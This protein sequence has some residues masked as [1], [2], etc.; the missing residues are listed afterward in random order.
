[1][2]ELGECHSEVTTEVKKLRRMIN[3]QNRYRLFFFLTRSFFFSGDSSLG[4]SS[5]CRLPQFKTTFLFFFFVILVFFPLAGFSASYSSVQSGDWNDPATWGGSGVP[6]SGDDVRINSGDEVTY[7]GDLNWTSGTISGNIDLIVTGDFSVSG[8]AFSVWSTLSVQ[9]GGDFIYSIGSFPMDSGYFLQVDGSFTSTTGGLNNSS[10]NTIMIGE[11]V[12]VDGDIILNNGA[13]TIGGNMTSTNGKVEVNN[14]SSLTI[15]G[16]LQVASSIKLNNGTLYVDGNSSATSLEVNN[17]STFFSGQDLAIGNSIVVNGGVIDVNG[18][19]STSDITLNNTSILAIDGDLIKDGNITINSVNSDLVVAGDFV[20]SGGGTTINND[21]GFYVFQFLDETS[22]QANCQAGCF[23]QEICN[24]C[25]IKSYAEWTVDSSPAEDYLD[26]HGGI[27]YSSGT[28]TVPDGV[29]SITVEVWGAGG[30]GATITSKNT[31]GGGGGGG[32]Y[33]SSIL[34]VTP[35]DTYNFIVGSGGTNGTNGGTTSFNSNSVV[36]EGGKGAE[37]NSNIGA[38]GGSSLNSVGNTIFDGGNGGNGGNGNN[39]NSGAGGGGAGS[40]GNGGDASGMTTGLGAN[41]N[42]GDGGVGVQATNYGQDGDSFGGGGSG[43]AKGNSNGNYT[44]GSGADGGIII[45]FT[46]SSSLTFSITSQQNVTCNGGSDGAATVSVGNGTSP[47]DYV[48]KN[49]SGVEVRSNLNSSQTEDIATGLQAGDYAVSVTDA[50]GAASDITVSITEPTVLNASISQ[51]SP[52][53]VSSDGSITLSGASGGSGNY[54]YSIDGGGSWQSSNSFT[55]LSAG[56]YNVQIRDASIPTCVQILNT[57]YSLTS[58]GISIPL[59]AVA[60]TVECQNSTNGTIDLTVPYPIQF[61]DPDYI[62]LGNMLMSNLSQFTLEGWIKVDLSTIGSRISLFGQNDAIEFGFSNSST[63]D[64][65]TASGGSVSTNVYPSDNAWHHVA[66]VGNGSTIILYIDGTSVATGGNSTGNYGS[67]TNYSSKI[68]AGVWDPS[69][70]NFLGQMT[71]VGFWN[72][73]LDG[74]EIASMASGYY[75]YQ[76][77]ESGLMAGYNFYEGLGTILS[78]QPTGNDGSFSGS[79]TWQDDYS[80]SWTKSGDAGFTATTQDLSGV[81]PGTYAVYVSNSSMGCSSNGSWTINYSDTTDPTAVCQDI[82]VNLDASGNVSITPAQVNNGS[83][84]NCTT[85]GNLALSLDISSFTCA[86]IGDNTVTLT[87]TDESGNSSTCNSTV[88]VVDNL[89]PTITCPDNITAVSTDGN[90]VVVSWTAP[91]ATDNCSAALTS[92]YDPGDS[93]PVGTTTV[94]YTSTDGEGNTADC[95]F[96]VTVT[97]NSEGNPPTPTHV[98]GYCSYRPITISSSVPLLSYQVE[99]T[100]PYD[101]KM[102]ADFSDLRF[103]LEDGTLLDYWIEDY[104]ASSSASVWVKIPAVSS[105]YNYIYMFYGNSS[106]SSL[107]NI[108]TTMNQG[109]LLEYFTYPGGSN[110]DITDSSEVTPQSICGDS[111]TSIDYDWG[112]GNIDLCG[113]SQSDRVVLRWTGWLKKPD[114]SGTDFDFQTGSDDGVRAYLDGSY[115]LGSWVLRSYGTDQ[116]YNYSFAR[117]IIPFRLDFYEN[118]GD[119]RV[120]MEWRPAGSG[121][122][123]IIPASN[124]YH[125]TYSATPPSINIGNEV[126]DN[127]APTI[128]C[129]GNITASSTDNPIQIDQ[130]AVSDNCQVASIV[131]D[132]NNTDD[133]SD[134]YPLGN[135]TVHWTVTDNSGNMAECDMVVN[136]QS[137]CSISDV[138]YTPITCAGDNDA[139]ITISATGSGQIEYSIDGGANYQ[140]SNIFTGISPGSYTVLIRDASDCTERWPDPIVIYDGHATL[141]SASNDATI[142]KGESIPL[143]IEMADSSMYFNGSSSVRIQNSNLINTGVQT[144]RTIALWFKASDVSSRQVIYEEGG[145]VNGISI[146]IEGGEIYVHIWERSGSTYTFGGEAVKKTISANEWTHVA[147]VFDSSITST[148]GEDN[149]KGYLNGD[150]FG[151]VYDSK[152]DNGLS[153]H[154]GDINIGRT[155]GGLVYAVDQNGS[156]SFFYTGYIDEF[157]LWNRPL[158]EEDIRSEMYNINDGSGSGSDL[159]V[160][161]NFNDDIGNTVSDEAGSNNGT[162]NG[163]ATHESDTPFTP[164]V[165]WSPT[166]DLL[167]TTGPSV[168]ATPTA[169][170][171]YTYTLTVPNNGCQT[172]G[173]ITVTVS[174]TQIDETLTNI[175]CDGLAD[176]AIDINVSGG[177][178]PYSFEWSTMD[179]SGLISTDEDQ[180]ELGV[181]TYNVIVTDANSCVANGSYS[182]AQ[183]PVYSVIVSNQTNPSTCGGNDGAIELSLSNVPDGVYDITYDAGAFTGVSVSGELATINNLPA[184][185]YNNLRL[186]VGPCVTTDDPD[187][188]LTDPP[189]PDLTDLSFAFSGGTDV[190]LNATATI[191][192]TSSSLAD[193]TYTVTYDLSAPNES[194]DETATLVFSSGSGSFTTTALANTGTTSLSITTVESNECSVAASA[195]VDI[196]VDITPPVIA[197]CPADASATCVENIETGATSYEDFSLIGT[198]SDNCTSGTN[199][200]VEF[201]DVTDKK[202]ETNSCEVKRTYTITDEAGNFQT[203]TQTFTITDSTPP[204]I[205]DCPNDIIDFADSNCEKVM[206]ITAP[207]SFTDGCGFGDLTVYHEYT[208]NTITVNGTGDLVDVAFPKGTTV[209]SW[210]FEDECGNIGTCETEVTINDV[211]EPTASTP[212]NQDLDAAGGC[213]VLIPDYSSLLTD[214]SDNCDPSPSI[215]QEPIIGTEVFADTDIKLVFTDASGNQD[216][217]IF[218][219]VLTSLAPLTISGM[220]YDGGLSGTGD[221]GSGQKP[222]IT[223]THTY[224]VD[225]IEPNPE[226][227]TYTWLVLDESGTDVTPTISF[228]NTEQTSGDILFEEASVASGNIYTIRVIKEQISGNCSAVFEFDVEVQETNFNSGVSPLGDSCQ[229]GGTGTT[230]VVFWD[231]DFTGGVEPYAFDFTVSDGTNG[232]TGSVS[233]LYTSDAQSINTSESCD[234]TYVV[235]ATKTSGEPAVQVAFIFTNQA[236]IDKDFNLTIDSATDNFS[237][238]KQTT[239]TDENDDVTLWGVPNTSE[240]TTD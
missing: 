12:T 81:E 75:H 13:I 168:T 105:G 124:Y 156:N 230:T 137:E 235:S 135:T 104:T 39:A 100:I 107:S 102:N 166:T 61:N 94:T 181:G 187:V 183:P 122:F 121:I 58:A 32:A 89:P 29:T 4:Q 129:P 92:D 31:G 83:N 174:D 112:N 197:T 153:N 140:T 7:S 214:L 110:P 130:P 14:N 84:D 171:T 60:N 134:I 194:T 88:T 72:R 115:T 123:S 236:G 85:S 185:I 132:Y 191:D 15:G 212:A 125:A 17:G 218:T 154:S 205:Q 143:S 51:T 66:V 120:T 36:A 225:A 170:T 63:L 54:G 22:S 238:T 77:I 86:N 202:D 139:T 175:S 147:L 215:T 231:I 113:F 227:Y 150:L 79:P 26:L 25:Q 38:A 203:C 3:P 224:V 119:A 40:A 19:V 219:A 149:F 195:S 173:T 233:N 76:G 80:Y 192:V 126:G 167:P 68:G 180:S 70:G 96:D 41:E 97:F 57:N 172:I 87:V 111:D 161:Y 133:A 240:I 162:I 237:I 226:N 10:A 169:T 179:G 228:N 199:L 211:T 90:P 216:S 138:S 95:N 69:G 159:I 145:T 188:V 209:V 232:C 56:T 1:M 23:P 2:R 6:V 11:N 127:I 55:G 8:G 239:N 82:T 67:D 9:V 78:S 74:G 42:G 234:G 50:N 28:F 204:V 201:S 65:W 45:S 210:S 217:V 108:S 59:L 20:S 200:T 131:N 207:G 73:A 223:S 93:F 213:S 43:A 99:L 101:S 114:G 24:T 206:S 103:S 196:P 37:T 144:Q 18:G 62:D 16:D 33:A 136:V 128:T 208:I 182:I 157:K 35:G 163:E 160:Y 44:G 30:G 178:E 186:S 158:T 106:S 198:V 109:L 49:S 64:C 165:T 27:F 47:Y 52:T 5:S 146:Y 53:C 71:K 152:G 91:S 229:D 177:T 46:L 164:M 118:G 98:D 190:C 48:W 220:T 151:G 176:G 222:F 184:G 155:G 221:V 21:G 34:N 141:Y 193:G 148:S 142:C 117:D 116:Y 189:T